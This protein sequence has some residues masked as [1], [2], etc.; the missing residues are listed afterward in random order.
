MI[1]DD[2][3]RGC[4]LILWLNLKQLVNIHVR[5]HICATFRPGGKPFCMILFL[6]SPLPPITI[7][8]WSKCKIKELTGVGAGGG[9]SGWGGNLMKKHELQ[10]EKRGGVL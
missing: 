3:S 1:K 2:K 8:N 4:K 10:V 9:G 6:I 7:L 5:S